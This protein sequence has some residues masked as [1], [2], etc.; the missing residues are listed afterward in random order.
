MKSTCLNQWQ[1]PAYNVQLQSELPI[2]RCVKP[3]L[4]KNNVCINCIFYLEKKHLD[5]KAMVRNFTPTRSATEQEYSAWKNRN[6]ACNLL[7]GKI[8][9][10]NQNFFWGIFQKMENGMKKELTGGMS[11]CKK[12]HRKYGWTRMRWLR[13]WK[14]FYS[15]VSGHA[16]SGIGP[17]ELLNSNMVWNVSVKNHLT[18]S[19]C[20]NQHI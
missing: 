2:Y 9:T 19:S 10:I 5:R 14:H 4:G 15:I 12:A 13:T 16:S 20:W 6:V 8:G 3:T 7:N 11:R 17:N 1:W 18:F